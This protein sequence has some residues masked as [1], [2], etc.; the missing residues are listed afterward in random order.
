MNR[1]IGVTHKLLQKA[2]SPL[3]ECE[4]YSYIH[5]DY[6]EI[7]VILKPNTLSLVVWQDVCYAVLRL[8]EELQA[9]AIQGSTPD[10]PG[11]LYLLLRTLLE[12]RGEISSVPICI[13]NA[14]L[15]AGEPSSC[16]FVTPR[17]TLC[18]S[19]S[20]I[21]RVSAKWFILLF[22]AELFKINRQSLCLDGLHSLWAQGM[23][24]PGREA[25]LCYISTPKA[26]VSLCG[27]VVNTSSY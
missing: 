9:P 14:I 18:H 26:R 4:F 12:E 15:G 10:A 1:N 8:T 25:N 24:R 21:N 5:E 11:T 2:H 17:S 3:P 7:P 16:V 19:R 23:T 27:R 6:W 13:I 20:L 22:T